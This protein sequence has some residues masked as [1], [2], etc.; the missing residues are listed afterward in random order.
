MCDSGQFDRAPDHDFAR[1]FLPTRANTARAGAPRSADGAAAAGGSAAMPLSRR[2]PRPVTVLLTGVLA[3]LITAGVVV[4][5][6]PVGTAPPA[7][8]VPV[9]D[10]AAPATPTAAPD[11]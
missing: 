6:R 5:V 1:R 7:A 2:L 11:P 9:S 10:T 3:G 4:A 8:S